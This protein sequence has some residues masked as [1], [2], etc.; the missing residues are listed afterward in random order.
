M[1]FACFDLFCTTFLPQI[2]QANTTL[3]QKHLLI[4][5]SFSN[6]AFLPYFRL[7]PGNDDLRSLA[8]IKTKNIS[9]P[10]ILLKFKSVSYFL[11]SW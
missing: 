11:I 4:K 1:R 5:L 2:M 6:L 3:N 10:S 9:P 7:R 8:I